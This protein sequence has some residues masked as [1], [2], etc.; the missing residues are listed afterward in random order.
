MKLKN[1][2]HYDV[3]VIRNYIVL[4]KKFK[5]LEE[6]ISLAFWGSYMSKKILGIINKC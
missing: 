2:F 3:D 4:I 5:N 6:M 1:T